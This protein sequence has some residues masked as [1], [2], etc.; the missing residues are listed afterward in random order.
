MKLLI[1][2]LAFSLYA[3]NPRNVVQEVMAAQLAP[4]PCHTSI[5][6]TD[7]LGRTYCFICKPETAP[8]RITLKRLNLSEA[9]MREIAEWVNKLK[10]P[11]P[12]KE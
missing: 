1:L 9:E 2:I 8:L 11:A 4:P 7:S 5:V 6:L 12:M 10:A 3:A